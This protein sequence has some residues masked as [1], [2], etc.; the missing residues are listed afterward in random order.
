MENVIPR[1]NLQMDHKDI[2]QSE[3]NS[4][5]FHREN[6]HLFKKYVQFTSTL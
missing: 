3:C 6:I 1:K 4:R 2:L 5:D